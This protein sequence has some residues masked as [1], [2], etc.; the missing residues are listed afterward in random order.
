MA[1]GQCGQWEYD[2]PITGNIGPCRKEV[3]VYMRNACFNWAST[4][5]SL[6]LI[7]I[8]KVIKRRLLIIIKRVNIN[9]LN[10]LSPLLMYLVNSARDLEYWIIPIILVIIILF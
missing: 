4:V 1:G 5:A 3:L 9:S 8:R 6:F 10:I 2:I 7:G